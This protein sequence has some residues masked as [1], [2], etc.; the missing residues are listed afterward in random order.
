MGPF[1]SSGLSLE[2]HTF[3]AYG[4]RIGRPVAPA[5]GFKHWKDM[6]MPRPTEPHESRDQTSRRAMLR[7]SAGAAVLGMTALS[8]NLPRRTNLHPRS[9]P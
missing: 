6:A 8:K 4:S 9:A 5:H 7:D 3:L 2:N 1:H